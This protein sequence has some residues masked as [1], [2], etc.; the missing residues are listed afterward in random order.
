MLDIFEYFTNVQRQYMPEITCYIISK[1]LD[2]KIHVVL[3]N[4]LPYIWFQFQGY[5]NRHCITYE[6][7]HT[8][9]F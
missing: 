4:L 1:L 5:K 3:K 2:Y 7:F 6:Y 8:Y 9:W